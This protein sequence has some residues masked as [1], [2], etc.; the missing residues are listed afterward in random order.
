MPGRLPN[1]GGLSS[2]QPTV[3]SVATVTVKTWRRW[4]AGVVLACAALMSFDGAPAHAQPAAECSVLDEATGTVSYE[5][6]DDGDIGDS[7][8]DGDEPACDLTGLPDFCVGDLGCWAVLPSP[9]PAAD[10]PEPKPAPDAVWTYR[11]CVVPGQGYRPYWHWH[12]P[13]ALSDEAWDAIGRLSTPSFTLAFNP[14]RMSFVN[15]ETW[16]WAEGIDDAQIT[17]TS[18]GGLVVAGTPARIELDPGD[19]VVVSCEW[20]TSMSDTCAYVYQRASVDGPVTSRAG[21]P[22]FEARARLIYTLHAERD[23]TRVEVPG[24]PMELRG[25]WAGTE[26]PVAEIHTLTDLSSAG[27]GAQRALGVRFRPTPPRTPNGR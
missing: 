26:V 25:V 27:D 11:Y 13:R 12:I 4:L 5:C 24:L 22:A 14:P 18:A 10:W 23:G 2:G 9:I 1:C 20:S 21:L 15:L 17:G 3:R 19:G 6:G 16:F 8:S 7:D